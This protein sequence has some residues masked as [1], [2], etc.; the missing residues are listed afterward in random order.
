MRHIIPISGKDSLATAIVQKNI[1]PNIDYE[2]VYNITGAELPEVFDWLKKVEKYLES[3]ILFVG[4]DLIDIIEKYKGFLPS[5]LARYCTRQAKI[6]PF[7]KWVGEEDCYVYYGIRADENR[8]GYDN[9][10]NEFITPIY[11]LRK[12]NIG[13]EQVYDIITSAEIKP[14]SFFW[15]SVYDSVVSKIPNVEI[16]TI[17]KPWQID[18]VF[19]WR[20]RANCFFCFNQRKSEWVGLLEHY[21]DLFWK[22]E[23]MEHVGS[24]YYWNSNG[25]SLMDIYA[26]RNQIKQRHIRKVRGL[27]SKI[28]NSRYSQS[29]LFDFEKEE[30]LIDFFKMTNCGLFC[31]K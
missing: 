28:Y 16:E 22:A 15:K 29:S 25:H 12:N 24:N 21:P 31:G 9:S 23:S 27:I 19:S 20:T 26:D 11:P 10:K 4:A 2:Y 30:G 14:P 13:I 6:E 1:N 3:D 18:Y 17:L 7:E 5:R 8:P